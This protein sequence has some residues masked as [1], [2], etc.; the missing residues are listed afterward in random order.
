VKSYEII[1]KT[2]P[3]DLH[4]RHQLG[5]AYGQLGSLDVAADVLRGLFDT[6]RQQGANVARALGQIYIQQKNYPAALEAFDLA[7]RDVTD[8][9]LLYRYKAQALEQLDR[10]GDAQILL[11]HAVAQLGDQ[12]ALLAELGRL[13]W[14][15]G[16]LPAARNYL[17]KAIRLAP[18]DATSHATLGRVYLSLSDWHA[19]WS[20]LQLSNR[21]PAQ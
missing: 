12:P 8:D 2:R 15:R 18:D 16:E 13:C 6:Y 5:I 9:P 1:S 3:E 19:A 17:D 20:A 21:A 7:L 14:L 4:S 11:M 10:A